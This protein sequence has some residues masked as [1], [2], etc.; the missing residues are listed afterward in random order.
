V[1]HLK[2]LPATA[3]LLLDP[4][5]VD[6]PGDGEEV[7]VGLV[8]GQVGGGRVAVGGGAVLG[9][10]PGPVGATKDGVEVG[11]EEQVERPAAGGVDGLAVV[12]VD[13]VEVRALF[14]VDEDGDE[15][16]VEEGGDR[17]V[18]EGVLC[19]E[20]ADWVWESVWLAG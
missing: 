15:G 4:E 11:G 18:G 19:C 6:L 1:Q 10:R 9:A 13:G 12:L 17:G 8:A 3:L 14:A 7:I 16:V 20:V 5:G 2:G